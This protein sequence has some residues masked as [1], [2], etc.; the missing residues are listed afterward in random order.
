MGYWRRYYMCEEVTAMAKA[1]AEICK[2]HAENV[3]VNL[4]LNRMEDNNGNDQRL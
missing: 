1:S 2:T 3:R 4:I